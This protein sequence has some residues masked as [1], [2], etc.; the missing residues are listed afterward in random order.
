MNF[1]TKLWCSFV[2]FA[3]KPLNAFNTA[4]QTSAS[5]IGTLKHD[6]SQLLRSYLNLL[7]PRKRLNVSSESVNRL[8]TRYL[9]M[10]SH[11]ELDELQAEVLKGLQ[12]HARVLA[13]NPLHEQ[14]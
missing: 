1:D 4:L 10:L 6:I 3:L 5:K 8:A 14:C 9:S 12:V 2:A 7:D 13:S 11:D